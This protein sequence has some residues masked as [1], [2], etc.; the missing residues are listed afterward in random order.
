MIEGITL[1]GTATGD[2]AFMMVI[3]VKRDHKSE[4]LTQQEQCPTREARGVYPQ[5]KDDMRSHKR[6]WLSASQGER[7]LRGN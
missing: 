1:I 2:R 3:K 7:G 4:S 6:R 5:R